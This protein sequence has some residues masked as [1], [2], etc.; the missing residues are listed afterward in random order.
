[1]KTVIDSEITKAL[2]EVT[3]RILAFIGGLYFGYLW[4][5]KRRD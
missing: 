5:K 2:I 4:G 1:M 3:Y